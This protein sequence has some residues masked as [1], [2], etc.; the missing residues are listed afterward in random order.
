MSR[1]EP[2]RKAAGETDAAPADTDH[3]E[4]ELGR[5][6]GIALEAGRA[7]FAALGRALV[8]NAGRGE[9]PDR[10][11]GQAPGPDAAET[12]ER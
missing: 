9:G 1:P 12:W 2:G 5:R 7:R 10:D 3:P 8:R 6:R 4:A 11:P